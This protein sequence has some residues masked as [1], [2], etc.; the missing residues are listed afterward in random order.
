MSR[1]RN[2]TI[3][4]WLLAAAATAC[5]QSP[6]PAMAMG[7]EDEAVEQYLANHNLTGMLADHLEM[8]LRTAPQGERPAVA[9]RLAEVYAKLL[10]EAE[11]VESQAQWEARSSTLLRDV[12]EANTIEL[13][14]GLSRAAY[15][16]VERVAEAW[17]LRSGPR[18]EVEQ[19]LRRLDELRQQFDSVASEAN[20]RVKALERQ[21]ESG[22]AA[23]TELLNVALSSA[24]RH[25]SLAHY[26][27]GWCCLYL[28]EL[29]DRADLVDAAERH[30]GW[31][32][33]ARPG[34]TPELSRLSEQTL[35][36]PHVARAAIAV[37]VCK[38]LRGQTAEALSWLDA[39]E[40]APE[41]PPGI[42]RQLFA[43]R[44][45]TLARGR[46]WADL[47]RIVSEHRAGGAPVVPGIPGV[48]GAAEGSVPAAATA[49]TTAE[50]RLLAVATLEDQ[51]QAQPSK[52][53]LVAVLRDIA[54][55]DLVAR[56][57][58]G[59]VL[60]LI[61]RYGREGLGGGGFVAQNIRGLIAY[62]RAREAHRELGSDPSEP[63][64][65]RGVAQLYTEAADLLRHAV[66]QSDASQYEAATA[67]AMV[68]LGMCLYNA[69]EASN[70]APAYVE[71][72]ERFVA[73][74]GLLT[75]ASRRAEA[76]WMAIRA[77]RRELD[78]TSR[79]SP[80]I[81]ALRESYIDRFLVSFPDDDRTSALLIGRATD[82]QM[83]PAQSVDLLLKVPESSRVYETARRQAAR[84]AYDLYREA[85]TNDRDWMAAR[86]IGIAEPML[87]IDRRR[88]AAGDG[89]AAQLAAVR[90]RQI[91]D[92][93]MGSSSPDLERAERALDVL[94][95]LI[96]SNMID[97]APIAGELDYR[98]AQILMAR[99]RP[100]DRQTAEALVEALQHKDP[101]Y[102]RAASLLFYRDALATL[103]RVARMRGDDG[104]RLE[105][106]G[107]VVRHGRRL[108][109]DAESSEGEI[110]SASFQ[111][112]QAE[113]ADAG[114]TVW[115][116]ERDE[117]ARDLALLLYRRLLRSQPR[118]AGFL[119]AHA[120]LSEAVGDVEAALESWRTLVAG[121]E[122]GSER[123]FEAKH[124]LILL[125]SRVDPERARLALQQH[126]V[127]Y[128]A[129]GPAPWGE[130]LDAID[131]SLQTNAGGSR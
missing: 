63:V 114:V 14:L 52:D 88:A 16:R 86:F 36:Y 30:F 116:L 71:A 10:E 17:R 39:V 3:A 32:L 83:T 113:V 12:P 94:L 99:N 129:L 72:S 84:I 29:N 123:W 130:R 98:R 110:P 79:P 67:N 61:H 100:G 85:P 38:G 119:R 105:A 4:A 112:L 49:L 53:P 77:L 11:D 33:N 26:L 20:Q 58:L 101:R 9:E 65:D 5:A 80:E 21:E 106:A 126:R 109:R 45:S 8:R 55:G 57:E 1:R 25:R 90:A 18:E 91:I 62:D 92:A 68:L 48:A 35:R 24:R 111:S 73:A 27:S 13:R 81:A 128:P 76:L 78:R 43:A 115:R 93:V 107:A 2:A 75:D 44:V 19:A 108:I 118:D 51:A 34:A 28:A 15:R 131:R 22:R 40:R 96:A 70:V 56:G 104:Q 46:Q 102:A 42:G 23:D 125:L 89:S 82:A 117:Q 95:S 124:G 60:E 121:L 103:R 122:A 6:R 64:T 66:T 31:L 127:L 54:L 37:G 74:S 120:E 69:G 41:L 7:P 87:V 97:G 50:A 47:N 59:H